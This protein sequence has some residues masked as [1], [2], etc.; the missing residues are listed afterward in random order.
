MNKN[1]RYNDIFDHMLKYAAEQRMEDM[2]KD[3]SLNEINQSTYSPE[4]ENRMKSYFVKV[5]RKG[6]A[7]RVS[8]TVLK[9]AVI[10][11]VFI[12]VSTMVIFNVEA[13]RVPFLNLFNENGDESI[14]INVTDE[15]ANYDSFGDQISGRYLPTFIPDDYHVDFIDMADNLYLVIY[16]ND[17]EEIILQNLYEGYSIAKDNEGSNIKDVIING[18]ASQFFEKDGIRTL[19]YKFNEDYYLM[20]GT[21]TED[22]L[23]HMAESMTYYS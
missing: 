3:I 7:H 13:F 15:K 1:D 11:V 19:I 10:A 6:I 2:G 4:F 5:K 23:I 17:G 14:T 9:I 21:V 16:K 18:E 20:T 12:A 22:E 8:R